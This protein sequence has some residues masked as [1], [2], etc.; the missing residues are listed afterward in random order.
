M[1]SGLL[2]YAHVIKSEVTCPTPAY[3]KLESKRM[4]RPIN[5]ICILKCD[6][7]IYII[8]IINNNNL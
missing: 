6:I 3:L 2:V 8:A 7:L 4:H 5:K 1:I